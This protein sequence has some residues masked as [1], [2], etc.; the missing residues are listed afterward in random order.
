M[1]RKMLI[2]A[3]ALLLG[4]MALAPLPAHAQRAWQ[5]RIHRQRILCDQGYKPACIKFGYWLGVNR[6]RRAEWRRAHPDWYWWQR[7]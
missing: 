4:G 7:W 1:T 6:G 2:G 5:A 3:A